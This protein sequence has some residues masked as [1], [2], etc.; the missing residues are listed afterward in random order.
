MCKKIPYSTLKL[1]S[2]IADQCRREIAILPSQTDSRE[3]I[4]TAEAGPSSSCQQDELLDEVSY[5]CDHA[6]LSTFN[7]SLESIGESPVKK[8]KNIQRKSLK[9]YAVR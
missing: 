5:K 1:G 6:A 9:R 2:Q 7:K 3:E 4:D 8:K